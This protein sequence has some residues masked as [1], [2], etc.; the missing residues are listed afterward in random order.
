M[1]WELMRD[2]ATTARSNEKKWYPD[3]AILS[4]VSKDQLKSMSQFKYN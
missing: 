1:S 3:H 4:G 2:I